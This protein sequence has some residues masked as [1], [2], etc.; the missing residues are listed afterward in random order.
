[1]IDIEFLKWEGQKPIS[2]HILVMSMIFDKQTESLTMI[3]RWCHES[4]S[5]PDVK[6]LLQLQITFLN[7]TF[8]KEIQASDFLS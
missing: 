7:S 5:G 4:L 8:E 1:M 3:L 2:K 6:E